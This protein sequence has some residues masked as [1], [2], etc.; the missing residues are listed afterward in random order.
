GYKF[1]GD[2][3]TY[4]SGFGVKYQ[5]I[6]FDYS[7]NPFGDYLPAVHRVSIGYALQ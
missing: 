4:S 5:D 2:Q 3:E 1:N 6:R 7:Y